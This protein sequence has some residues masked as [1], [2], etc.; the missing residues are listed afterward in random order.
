MTKRVV[1]Q[2]C[3]KAQSACI[4]ATIKMIDNQHFLHILQDPSEEKKAIGTAKILALSLQRCEITTANLFDEGLFD[5]DNSYLLFP[6]EAAIPADSL[7]NQANINFDSHFIILDGSWKKAYKLLMSNPFL[8]K[9]PKVAITGTESSHYRIRKSPREDGL[10]TVEAG[11]YLLSQLENESE[12]YLPLLESFNAMIDYQISR[13]PEGT[14]KKHY[15]DKN[16]R[17]TA[18]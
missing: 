15:L 10:S 4:C 16:S 12:K 7:I 5:I 13:M 1:C 9:L 2:R 14:Y 18:S 3:L 17:E 6:D 8:Q 11:Y